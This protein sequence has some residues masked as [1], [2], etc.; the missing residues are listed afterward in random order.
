[1]LLPALVVVA[2]LATGVALAINGLPWWEA[3]PPASSGAAE[4]VAPDY[5][6]LPLVADRSRAR[7]VARAGDAELIAAPAGQDGYCL[8]L[9]IAGADVGSR[10]CSSAPVN[11]GRTYASPPGSDDPQWLVYGRVVDPNAA[12]LDLTEA[13]GVPLLIP[14]HY[15]GF[16][17]GKVPNDRWLAL[18]DQAGEA[19]ILD[20]S[21]RTIRTSCVQWGPAP[22][23]AEL[24]HVPDFFWADGPPCR[25]DRYR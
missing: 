6:Q 17:L 5:D 2:L 13:A 7:T 14:L 18:N 9:V 20:Q 11:E 25:P 4:L 3:A 1:V 19:R 15:T 16:F 10:P 12:I 21:G 8:K 23:S 24:G 22:L